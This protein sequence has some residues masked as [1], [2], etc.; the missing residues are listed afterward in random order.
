MRVEQAHD[1][2]RQVTVTADPARYR[3]FDGDNELM[4]KGGTA[5]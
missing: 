4:V 5:T 1:E 3:Q 2:L